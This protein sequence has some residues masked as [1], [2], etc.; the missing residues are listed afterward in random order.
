M[1]EMMKSLGKHFQIVFT[2]CDKFEYTADNEN[3]KRGLEV[4]TTIQ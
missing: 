2:K 3:V 4:A 1:L